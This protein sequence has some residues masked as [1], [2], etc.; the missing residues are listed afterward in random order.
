MKF[1]TTMRYHFVSANLQELKYP[2]TTVGKD[3]AARN[4]VHCWME[5]KM[6]RPLWEKQVLCIVANRKICY[7]PP[8][9]IPDTYPKAVLSNRSRTEA[10]YGI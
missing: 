6:A 10:T 8:V 1:K 7:D 3:R 2:P 9:L 4:H 5:C